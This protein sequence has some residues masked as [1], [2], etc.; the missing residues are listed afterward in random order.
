M[1]GGERAIMYD[2]VSG[3]LPAP[4]GEGTHFRI[5]WFQT[6][7]VMDIRT[8]PRSIS[9]VT[10]TKGRR[11]CLCARTT[12]QQHGGLPTNRAGGQRVGV[13]PPSFPDA[14]LQ[15]VN[16]TLRV[17]SKPEVGD[18][19]KIFRVRPATWDTCRESGRGGE[20]LLPRP[21]CTLGLPYV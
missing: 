13:L 6:P 1:D 2:R 14:D 8:R 18:L 20:R 4:V 19:A 9:S 7:N 17:L 11:A 3:I 12:A 5:P 15:M 21:G 10:G 16:I